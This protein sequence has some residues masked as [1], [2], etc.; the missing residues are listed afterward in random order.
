MAAATMRQAQGGDCQTSG[1]SLQPLF[2]PQ[3]SALSLSP[4]RNR[5][6]SGFSP[7]AAAFL[8]ASNYELPTT[9]SSRSGLKYPVAVRAVIFDFDGLIIDSETPLFDIWARIYEARGHRLTMDEWQHA[10][11]T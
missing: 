6:P 11:G 8:R 10:L 2:S 5:Q 7:Q 9:N 3:P 4:G 1:L